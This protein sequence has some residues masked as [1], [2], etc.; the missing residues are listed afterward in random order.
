MEQFFYKNGELHSEGVSIAEITK[1]VQ[2]PLYIYSKL[3]MEKQFK[4]LSSALKRVK[5]RVFYSVKANSNI[6]VLKV[7]QSLGAGMDVVSLGEYER[8]VAAGVSGEN[9]V[10]SGVG[11]TNS[12]IQKVISG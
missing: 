6:S 10:F 12:E 7:F 4:K 11:K 1:E 3:A 8:A 5:H 2:T 9:I